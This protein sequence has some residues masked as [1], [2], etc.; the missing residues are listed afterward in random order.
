[1]GKEDPEAP[2]RALKVALLGQPNVGKSSLF[3]RLTGVGVISSNY[4]GTTVTFD[5]GAIV[6]NGHTVIVKD[7]PGTYSVSG[8]SDD[9]KVV[10]RSLIS[11]G[12]DCVI[13]VADATSLVGS[14][15][16][17]IEAMELGI[18]AI[19]ALN[20]IDAARRNTVIDRERLE[21]MLGIPV[22]EVSSKTSEGVDALAD[23]ICSGAARCTAVSPPYDRGVEAA[24]SSLSDAMPG[25]LP[26]ARR[27]I[28]VKLLE[29]SEEFEGIAGERLTASAQAISALY[30]EEE[31][32]PIAV[33]MASA[34]YALAGTIESECLKRVEVQPTMSERISDA[35][36]A[37]RTGIPVLAAVCLGI[38]AVVVY[39]G[40][41]LDS[42]V[43]S[44]YEAVVGTALI[45]FGAGIGG[46]FGE[47]VFTGID[48]SFQAILTLV[49]PYI[50]VF[51]LMLGVL[52]DSGY[53]TRAVVLL[54]NTMHR[55]GLHGGAF[56]PMIVG[57]GCNVPAIMAVRTIH[58]RREKIILSAMIV[59]AVPCS[60]Q[61]AIIFGAT[62]KFSGLLAALCI[63]VMLACLGALTGILLNRFLKYEPSNLAMELPPLQ[64]PGIRNILSKTWGRI[65]DFIY[66]ALP[67][68]VIGSI[69]IE[70]LI[71]YD[72]LD[73][74]VDPLS[75]ITVGLLG[76]PA[77]CIISFIV[78]ILRKEMALGMLQILAAGVPLA[79]FMTPGQFVVFGAVMAVYMP[80]IATLATMWREIGWKETVCVSVM[81]AVF[82]LIV[83]T[84]ANLIVHMFRW[85]LRR[86]IKNHG[87]IDRA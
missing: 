65:K 63:L 14:L 10:V 35:L 31:G 86:I 74:I 16:L 54:D 59:T 30:S 73:P 84:G 1:M 15:V 80:C 39:G 25:G 56:I 77:V 71:T 7:L 70:I 68:L 79:E 49:I 5:E 23:A 58:S 47:A 29:G 61:M 24:I 57:I 18:P 6:R 9:E 32:R 2:E 50:L 76:L 81:T 83:G 36:I 48:G 20:K 3:S 44:A 27:G 33:S 17:C 82:A 19:L 41:F 42:L 69:V 37:P 12:Y 38:L 87:A 11:D 64:M 28:A 53:L 40:S 52:E 62:G 51:Y 45:D 55:F 66:I 78:G 4:P 26:F 34:R 13:L 43:S 8:N 72:L 21:T 22:A 75:P 67:L 60:A 46:K 85:L